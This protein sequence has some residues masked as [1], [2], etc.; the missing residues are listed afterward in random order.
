MDSLTVI[1]P[2]YNEEGVIEKVV[3]ETYE[4]IVEPIKGA[5][6]VVVNDGSKD[7]TGEILDGLSEELERFEV[8]HK[9]NSGHGPSVLYAL[10]RANSDYIFL[11]DSDGQYYEEDF[12]K[13]WDRRK[14]A[15]LIVGFRGKRY[16][17][18]HRLILTK[19]V[20]SAL[21]LLLKINVRDS[22]SP[23]KLISRKVWDEVGPLIPADTLAPSIFIVVGAVRKGFRVME[24]PVRHK[25]RET[26]V[27]S[28]RYFKL[29]RFSLK[30]F[31]ELMA[32]SGKLK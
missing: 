10:S 18:M 20:R 21:Y 9:A 6:L 4:H 23:F 13:L 28:I 19:I 12:T 2:A 11:M 24:L 32:F 7:N 25:A 16:D 31:M 3:R 17:P 15:D 30:A 8:H 5:R 29:I 14:D 1:M 26:G 27:C 22:N